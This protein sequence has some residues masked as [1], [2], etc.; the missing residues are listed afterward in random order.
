MVFCR[1]LSHGDRRRFRA[2][3]SDWRLSA[4]EQATMPPSSSLLPPSLPWLALDRRTFQSLPDGE[5]HRFSDG[6]AI[7]VC[8]GSFDGSLLYYHCVFQRHRRRSS[9]RLEDELGR[10]LVGEVVAPPACADDDGRGSRWSDLPPDLAGMVFCRLLSHGDRRRFRAICSDW[11]LS[12]REQATMPPSSSLL[13]P[14]LPWLA[15]DRR[16]FQSLPDGEVHRFSDGPAITVCRGSFDGSLLY[17][18]YR[19]G[20]NEFRS[21]FL[22]NPFSGAVLD[23]P[24]HCVSGGGGGGGGEPMCFDKAIKRRIVVCSPDLVAATVEHSS[25]IWCHDIVVVND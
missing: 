14:S 2:I 20:Y 3:C 7:T 22:W 11:R 23:L 12:A 16:T 25:L 15:L 13:P 5:V 17:Y 24:V 18:Q 21:N 1:L 6:P 4:R 10:N 8:R 19:N 9:D